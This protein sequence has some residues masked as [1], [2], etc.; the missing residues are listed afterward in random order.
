[1]DEFARLAAQQHEV[2]AEIDPF[3]ASD[4]LDRDEVHNHAVH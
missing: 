3:R 2:T 4:R 1:M